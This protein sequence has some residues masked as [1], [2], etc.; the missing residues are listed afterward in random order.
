MANNVTLP[1]TGAVVSTR[2]TADSEHI[3]QVQLDIGTGTDESPVSASNPLPVDILSPIAF[4][5]Q[6]IDSEEM[7]ALHVLRT[8]EDGVLQVQGSVDAG[9]PALGQGEME[10]SLP[11]VIASDQGDVGVLTKIYDAKSQPVVVSATNPV[12]VSAPSDLPVIVKALDY[13]GQPQAASG[14]NP[15]PTTI[16]NT[17]TVIAG[18]PGLGQATKANSLPVVVASDQ[19]VPVSGPLTDTQ[20]RASSIY[21]NSRIDVPGG[22]VLVAPT[23]DTSA[24]SDGDILFTEIALD[25]TS[26]GFSSYVV[27]IKNV[28]IIDKD[29][30]K[31]ALDLLFFVG[32]PNIGTINAAP[33]ISDTDA[34]KFLGMVSIAAAD[35]YDLGG[36]SVVFKTCEIVYQY[37]YGCYIVGISK[38]TKTYAADGMKIS[39]GVSS[40]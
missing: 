40:I 15:L 1:G 36:V 20:L 30:N 32:D 28:R 11:V 22:K 9:V 33:S 21:T 5:V 24:Y 39:L 27:K 35:Y 17:P 29:D 3:Q 6:G 37:A 18:L 25:A 14:S 16:V 34:E 19:T 12:P 23:L 26:L 8:D 10:A 31:G 2:E 13:W 38:D 7:A 4:P